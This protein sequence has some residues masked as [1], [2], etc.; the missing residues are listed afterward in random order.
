MQFHPEVVHTPQ[1]CGDAAQLRAQD[2]GLR[3]GLDEAGLPR[4]GD[5]AHPRAGW[6][7]E[8]DLRAVGRRGFPAVV[9]VLLHEAIGDRLTCIFVDHGLLRQGE[10][11]EVERLFRG[12][13]SSF[14][15]NFPTAKYPPFD[16]TS[17]VT[18]PCKMTFAPVS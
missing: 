6:Q 10:A 7:R 9:A 11:E 18:G 16:S 17:Y 14:P 1:R 8:G 2:R 4:G 5:R 3:R 13:F 12:P 15:V